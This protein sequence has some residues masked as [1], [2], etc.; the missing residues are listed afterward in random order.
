MALIRSRGLKLDELPI[1]LIS[2]FPVAVFALGFYL[3]D[4]VGIG[5]YTNLKQIIATSPKHASTTA[6]V[7]SGVLW[8]AMAHFYLIAS[9]GILMFL[10][11]WRHQRVRGL[12]ALPFNSMAVF[13]SVLGL[14]LLHSVDFTDRPLRG[15]FLLTFSSLKQQQFLGSGP[16]LLIVQTTLTIINSLSIIV[17]ALLCSFLPILLLK[18]REGWSQVSL[19]ERAAD[20]RMLGIA[21]SIFMVAG[22]VHMFAWMSWAPDLLGQPKLQDLVSSVILYWSCIWTLML[23]VLYVPVLVVFNHLAVSVMEDDKVPFKDRP[24]WLV[25]CGISF[26]IVS[27]FPQL[28]AILAPLISA[29]LT[30]ILSGLPEM[31][32][33]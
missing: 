9:L 29:P 17:P 10:I 28:L 18:P 31:L 11:A 19:Q 21:G 14:C 25:D 15:I 4:L 22:V 33:K 30:K 24:Q 8:A 27:Q 20:L 3:F 5:F 12:A 16:A 32:A 1:V 23:V 13:L 2:F 26:R 6:A 7:A